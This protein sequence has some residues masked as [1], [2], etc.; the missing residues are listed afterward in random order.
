MIHYHGTPCGGVSHAIDWGKTAEEIGNEYE[1]MA[2]EL[3]TLREQLSKCE[4][5]RS[6]AYTLVTELRAEMQEGMFCCIMGMI[7]GR[8]NK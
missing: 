4:A 1:R 6:E 5:D 2:I 7:V 3:D 8:R